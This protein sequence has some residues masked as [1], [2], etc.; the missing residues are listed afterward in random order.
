MRLI[1]SIT[2]GMVATSSLCILMT[3]ASGRNHIEKVHT[4]ES[5]PAHI[6]AKAHPQH[7]QAMRKDQDFLFLQNVSN[8]QFSGHA[9]YKHS[10]RPKALTLRLGSTYHGADAMGRFGFTP[11]QY[12]L[13]GEWTLSCPSTGEWKKGICYA[14]VKD[15]MLNIALTEQH[16][17]HSEILLI[18]NPFRAAEF[19]DH[20]HSHSLERI[21][22]GGE[23]KESN[24]MI[25]TLNHEGHIQTFK[26]LQSINLIRQQ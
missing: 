6:E 3:Q 23:I 18:R 19:N 13:K 10:I 9:K 25:G 16:S 7:I 5:T 2:L 8:A 26:G 21:L 20:K 1:K 14:T 12:M 22:A 4:S 15:S 11:G 24:H 17:G